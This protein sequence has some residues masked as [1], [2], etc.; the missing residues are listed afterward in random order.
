MLRAGVTTPRPLSAGGVAPWATRRGL[1][2]SATHIGAHADVAVLFR[3]DDDRMNASLTI[4]LTPFAFLLVSYLMTATGA[5]KKRLTWKVE[6][7]PVCHR[8]RRNC[9]CRWL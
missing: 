6:V 1:W 4:A 5:A 3:D 8:E 9:T 2:K 7:C